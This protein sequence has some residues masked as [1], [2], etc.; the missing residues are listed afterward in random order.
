MDFCENLQLS[1]LVLELVK[2]S[3]IKIPN[4]KIQNTQIMNAY[5][6][7]MINIRIENWDITNL[8]PLR[9]ISPLRFGLASKKV[10]VVFLEVF[11]SLPGGFFLGM[12]SPLNFA[13]FNDLAACNSAGKLENLDGFLLVG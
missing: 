2:V 10:W 4:K 1:Q 13:K 9:W 11:F 6:D 12:V 5:D 7:L 3:R 8:P